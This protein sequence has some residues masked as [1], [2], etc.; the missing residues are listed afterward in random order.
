VALAGLQDEADDD[1]SPRDGP[2]NPRKRPYTYDDD[3]DSGSDFA[4][5]KNQDVQKEQE[6]GAMAESMDDEG[7]GPESDTQPPPRAVRMTPPARKV[8]VIAKGT[9]KPSSNVF[10]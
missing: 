4:P 9:Q 2:S 5:E 8:K 7:E 1:R 6:E 10:S 3:V